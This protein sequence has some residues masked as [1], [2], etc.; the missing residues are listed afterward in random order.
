MKAVLLAPKEERSK[1]FLAVADAL[2]ERG[3]SVE[4]RSKAG[5]REPD[6]VICWGRLAAPSRAAVVINP[7]KAVRTARSREEA[8]LL[9]HLHGIPV[10]PDHLPRDA[11]RPAVPQVKAAYSPVRVH[12][13]D[14]RILAVEDEQGAMSA[15]SRFKRQRIA[16]GACRAIY[17][18]GLHFGALD[19]FVHPSGRW[20][21]SSVDPRPFVDEEL[22]RAY[23][24]AIAA[25]AESWGAGPERPGEAVLGADPE[26]ALVAQGGKLLYA[27][28]YVNHE[29]LVGYDRQ[30][31]ANRGAV[32]PLAEI[33]P[34]PSPSPHTLAENVE[35]ALARAAE[36]L[37]TRG[38]AWLGG[39]FPYG[40]YPTGGHI[41]FSGV[42]LTTPFLQALDNYLGIPVMLLEQRQR[43]KKRRRQYGRAGDF[44]RKEHGG[45]EYR[46]LPSWIVSPEAAEA[47]LCLA[48]AVAAE[49]PRLS[50]NY[51]SSPRAIKEFYLSRKARFR[52]LCP[53]LLRSVLATETGRKYQREL[54]YFNRMIAGRVEWQDDKDIKAAW[55]L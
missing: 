24:A 16:E 40:A 44:R 18:L 53:R 26:F 46:V 11:V 6:V 7:V 1:A 48:K 19:L 14:L 25:M 37:P 9:L 2:T 41:H 12:V 49:W 22:A 50:R 52:E 31:R 15:I 39:S 8:S 32:F 55:R 10:D 17:V 33:R 36:L 21:V 29:G 42:P 43:A 38:V 5:A 30:S 54:A 28:R 34:N 45:F 13:A 20:F 51:L 4:R 27:S 3:F 35:A 23:G 47:T